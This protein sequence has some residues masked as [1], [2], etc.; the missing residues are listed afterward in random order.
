ML[1]AQLKASSGQLGGNSV[2]ADALP[3]AF[4]QGSSLPGISGEVESTSFPW[5]IQSPEGQELPLPLASI[6]PPVM[7]AQ[8]SLT[9]PA[10]L[11][12]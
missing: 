1:G 4:S 9:W 2:T 12:S 11:L 7:I 5:L 3:F 8:L 6:T 10:L